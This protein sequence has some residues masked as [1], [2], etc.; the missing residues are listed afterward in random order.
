M[1]KA[2]GKF[3]HKG[4]LK[5]SVCNTQLDPRN[6]ESYQ[7]V[8]Y[9]RAHKPN[10]KASQT[11]DRA[12]IK[13]AIK[14]QKAARRVQGVSKTA[15]MTFAP[16]AF[17]RPEGEVIQAFGDKSATAPV[18]NYEAPSYEQGFDDQ[19]AT[20]DDPSDQFNNLSVNEQGYDEG[21][22]DEGG[23]YEEGG[24]DEGYAEEGYAEEGYAEAGYDQGYAEE[25]YA[26]EGYA[27]EGYYEEGY[28]EGYYE[29]G[30]EE[31]YYEEGGYDEGYYEEGY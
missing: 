26:E 11:A 9:C 7:N 31:G 5:C 10:P 22:Y 4:C 1:G 16:G 27:E 14:V 21:G 3:W 6:L 15:R 2:L 29:E 30:Y 8:P 28:D 19:G 17:Q 18:Q 13:Q 24:Y 23:Y 20:Y 12:D 25:G